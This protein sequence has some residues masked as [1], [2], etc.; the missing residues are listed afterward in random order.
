MTEFTL[1]F[2]NGGWVAVED[3]QLD[4]T[5][6][7]RLHPNSRGRWVVDQFYLDAEEHELTPGIIKGLRLSE[8]EQ[9]INI[10]RDVLTARSNV[11]SPADGLP[12]LAAH[13][14]TTFGRG[15]DPYLNWVDAAWRQ[16]FS[17]E[18]RPGGYEDLVTPRKPK[19]GTK[20]TPQRDRYRLREAPRHGLTDEFLRDVARA[21]NAAISRGE[22]RPN[23]V[24]AKDVQVSPRTV[25]EWVAKA[26]RRGIMPP[27][28]KGAVG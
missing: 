13:F 2:G 17:P 19:S 24:I 15:S 21:Y 7:L 4:G 6:Y 3:D 5:L 20:V 12:T 22:R 8:Y 11:P 27:G 10:E 1:S 26:R 23:Q 14:S 9:E 18:F 16:Q 28:R 25:Q